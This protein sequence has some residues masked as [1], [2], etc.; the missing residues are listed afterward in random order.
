MTRTR[1]VQLTG[2]DLDARL[3]QG[4][5]GTVHNVANKRINETGESWS[6]VYKEYNAAMLQQLDETALGALVG[7]LDTIDGAQGRWLCEKAAWPAA[8]VEDGGRP[9]GFLMRAV[10]DRFRFHMPG[11]TAK[12][13][14]RERLAT[15]EFLLNDDAYVAGIGLKVSD[16]D[17]LLLLADLADILTRLHRLG[18][19]V[20]DLSP[21]N[22]LFALGPAPECFLI[23]CDAMR[24]RGASVLPQAE[25]PDWQVP[26]G[27][28]KA[29]R[30][31][32]LYKFGLLAIRLFA[33]DQ[34][35]QDPDALAAVSPRLRDLAEASLSPDPGLRPNPVAWTEALEPAVVSASGAQPAKQSPT[36]TP[37]ATTS[38][39]KPKPT[40]NPDPEG[41]LRSGLALIAGLALVG[42]YNFM[43]WLTMPNGDALRF[44]DVDYLTLHLYMKAFLLALGGLACLLADEYLG[45]VCGAV[46]GFASFCCFAAGYQRLEHEYGVAD[47][48]PMVGYDLSF[49][50][51]AV[52]VAV[53]AW[54]AVVRYRLAKNP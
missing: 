3:G 52:V 29:T 50:A 39:P 36:T 35:A 47:I 14:G 2:L 16:R 11:L 21:K 23:D 17:R 45:N 27:E 28:E 20:G 22:L 42:A 40:A 12:S 32:D 43:P 34:S 24:L 25:T 4:G 15:V 5:Q 9:R 8:V 38:T 37:A 6:V 51:S 44:H 31:S 19:T 10:P 13:A 53:C 54:K 7:L 46:L 26:D 1:A 30:E 41:E 18:I 48:H 49:G 33:R